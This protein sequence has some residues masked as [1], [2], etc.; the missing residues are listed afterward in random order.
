MKIE[1]ASE[2]HVG[3]V[4]TRNEDSFVAFPEQSLYVVADGLG[5][6]RAGDVA[7]RMA[8]E[9]VSRFFGITANGEGGAW[10]HV[11]AG[12]QD[13]NACRLVSSVQYA[14]QCV[15]KAQAVAG[16]TD[17]PM[18]TT[19]VALHFVDSLA[20]VAH[21]GD[22]RCYCYSL[23]N[24]RQL[25]RDHTMEADLR[26]RYELT[27]EEEERIQALRHVVTRA[28]GANGKPDLTV[29]ARVLVPRP[30]DLFLL[31]SDG[32]HSEVLDQHIAEAL[33]DPAPLQDVCRDLIAAAIENG[34]SD[35]ITA[36]LVRFVEGDP[37]SAIPL[38]AEDTQELTLEEPLVDI[39][40][41]E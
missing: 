24:L 22:C 38:E 20:F 36:M 19:I 18:G 39:I 26:R 10:P 23:G 6:H 14:H 37:P 28:L 27:A 4:R 32:L 41:D 5:G 33:E 35:N 25:T 40:D 31:C 3:L 34:G 16:P 29:E 7:S 2:T 30:G 9:S 21:V 15:L 1:H 12:V 17:T 8:V 13:P 11:A